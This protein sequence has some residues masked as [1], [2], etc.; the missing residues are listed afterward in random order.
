[1]ATVNY[2]VAILGNDE[3]IISLDIN[4]ANWRVQKANVDATNSPV[5]GVRVIVKQAGSVI[6]EDVAPAGEVTTW[7]TAPFQLGWDS[8]NGGLILGDYEFGVQWGVM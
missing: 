2:L 1:M 7:N 5:Y 6:W 8:V 4:N 3:V